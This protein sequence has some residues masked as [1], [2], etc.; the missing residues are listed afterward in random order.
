MRISLSRAMVALASLAG[1]SFAP[2][3]SAYVPPRG[4][5]KRYRIT[6]DYWLPNGDR[7]RLRRLKQIAFGQLKPSNDFAP[8]LRFETGETA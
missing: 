5:R 1:L 2:P 4:A 3:P 6:R 7:E 8:G